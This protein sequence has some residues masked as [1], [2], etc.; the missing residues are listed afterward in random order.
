MY[1]NSNS[2]KFNILKPSRRVVNLK[3]FLFNLTETIS[4]ELNI[5]N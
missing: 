1:E 5:I 3:D 2:M 4:I